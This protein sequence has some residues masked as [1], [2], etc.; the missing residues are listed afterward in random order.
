MGRTEVTWWIEEEMCIIGKII[1]L[2]IVLI[3]QGRAYPSDVT[4][5]GQKLE[6]VKRF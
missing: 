3:V 2:A 6:G 1:Y 5:V 4:V